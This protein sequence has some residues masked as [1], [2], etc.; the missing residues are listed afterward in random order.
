MKQSIRY[1][2]KPKYDGY[3]IDLAPVIY[4]IFDKKSATL[5]DKSSVNT[6]GGNTSTISR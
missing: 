5:A 2:W 6:S 4:N 3:Q 1:C